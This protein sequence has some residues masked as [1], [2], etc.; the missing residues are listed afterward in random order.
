V[1]TRLKAF[2]RILAENCVIALVPS[3]FL[4]LLNGSVP[5]DQLRHLAVEAFVYVN[6]IVFLAKGTLPRLYPAASR[7]GPV[8]LWT[9]FVSMLI[10]ISAVGSLLGS[11]IL[12]ALKLESRTLFGTLLINSFR[13]SVFLTLVIGTARV[14]F[15]HIHGQLEN[16]RLKLRT[17]ELERERALKLATE[18][19]LTSLEA[20]LH[21]HFLFN[22]LNSISSLIPADP[23]RAERMVERMAALLR[24][25]LDAH[26]G[27]L[28]T[29]ERELKIVRDYLE[30]EQARLGQ[31]LR[32]QLDASAEL[33]ECT[34]PPLSIQTLVENSIKYAVA[35]DRQGGEI[36]VQAGRHN[37]TLRI[38]VAD[39]GPGFT[40]DSAHAGHGLDNLRSRLGALFGTAADLR[41]DRLD[42][43]T[44]VTLQVPPTT[45]AVAPAI[46]SPV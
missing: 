45:P 42:G 12:V 5:L 30:I 14:V 6:L 43:W 3:V 34:V 35:P 2:L 20:R 11:L 4:Y 41:V 1:N 10:L 36:R 46:S 18:A 26:Q 8:V 15:E 19:R 33:M 9:V 37:G 7:R 27:G 21:P 13:L 38:D 28:V 32:Y 17:E 16:T 25:S 39:T 40:M 24:F 23:E 44:T 22:T 29:L 31:R